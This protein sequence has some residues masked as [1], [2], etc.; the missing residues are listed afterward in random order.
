M[1][2]KKAIFIINILKNTINVYFDTF[3]VFYFFD[4]ANYEVLPLAK[5]YLTLYLFTGIGFYLIRRQM[6]KNIHMP[7]FRLGISLQA[8]YIALI[9]LLKDKIIDYIFLVGITKGLAD[10]FYHY[11]KNLFLTNKITNDDRQHYYGL[12]NIVNKLT[13]IVVP[14]LLGVFLTFISYINLGKIFFMLFILMFIISFY[15]KDSSYIDKKYSFKGFI[16]IVKNNKNIKMSMFAFFFSGFTYASGVM[17]TI[18]KLSQINIFKT[19]LNLGIVDSICA[20]LFL[21]ISIFF[22]TKLHKKHF[23]ISMLI[24][25]ILSFVT[26]ILFSFRPNFTFFIIYLLVRNSFVGLIQLIT[27]N[28]T[29]NLSNSKELQEEYKTEYYLARDVIF[30]ISRCIGYL[31]LL[32]VCLTIGLNYINYILIIPA[33]SLFCE[34]I[35]ISKISK[36]NIE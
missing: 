27:E 21:G 8:I 18:I 35:L 25:G 20:V 29:T 22:T 5:Y 17:L 15:I 30:A 10:G 9:M 33:I 3:F 28:V 11:P 7:Y 14:L 12:L 6:K 31:L 36:E 13:S 16:K 4:V 32:I 23:K 26:L 34:C 19:N 2:E 24:S 1:N